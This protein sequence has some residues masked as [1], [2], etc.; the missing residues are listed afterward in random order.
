[1]K[2]CIA[3]TCHGRLGQVACTARYLGAVLSIHDR[4][5]CA[6]PPPGMRLV[7]LRV[8]RHSNRRAIL[9]GGSTAATRSACREG[10]CD[11]HPHPCV[12]YLMAV[13][14]HMWSRI[15]EPCVAI[16]GVAS[17]PGRAEHLHSELFERHLQPHCAVLCLHPSATR[18]TG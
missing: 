7:K 4:L 13:L 11:Y 3:G 17:Q 16:V 14:L 10:R 12:A 9:H 15:F 6:H 2:Y 1:M 5:W 8:N 18:D